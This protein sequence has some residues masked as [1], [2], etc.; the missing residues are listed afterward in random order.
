MP[1]KQMKCIAGRFDKTSINCN[2]NIK[3]IAENFMIY[4][5]CWCVFICMYFVGILAITI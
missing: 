4:R 1:S 5:Y 3:C 2:F